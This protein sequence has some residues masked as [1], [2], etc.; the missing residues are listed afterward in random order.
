MQRLI[1]WLPWRLSENTKGELFQRLWLHIIFYQWASNDKVVLAI[2]SNPKYTFNGYEIQQLV[3]GESFNNADIVDAVNKS[4][5]NGAGFS[6][7]AKY[8]S[9]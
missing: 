7:I 1:T 9:H 4:M 3:I 6:Y 5:L 8:G 2:Q